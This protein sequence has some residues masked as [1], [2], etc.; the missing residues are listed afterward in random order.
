MPTEVIIFDKTYK[1]ECAPNEEHNLH[2]AAKMLEN[3]FRE[4]R[5]S[6]PRL[7]TDRIGAMVAFNLV[8]EHAKLEHQF[9]VFSDEMAKEKHQMRQ[10]VQQLTESLEAALAAK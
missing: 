3:K 6:M 5:I 9:R 8:L 7:E 4:T 2:V 1:F 10:L